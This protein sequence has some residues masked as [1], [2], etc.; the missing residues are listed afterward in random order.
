MFLISFVFPPQII[1]KIFLQIKAEVVKQLTGKQENT[2]KTKWNSYCTMMVFFRLNQ[3]GMTII[4]QFQ[5]E[6]KEAKKC[7]EL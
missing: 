2:N 6:L 3:F 4:N 7:S 5:E 1:P